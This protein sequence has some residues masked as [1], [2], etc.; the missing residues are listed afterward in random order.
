[1]NPLEIKDIINSIF[2]YLAN[3]EI[4]KVMPVSKFCYFSAAMYDG[5]KHHIRP[6]ICNLYQEY[7]KT[8]MYKYH[9]YYSCPVNAVC[10]CSASYHIYILFQRMRNRNNDV[11]PMSLVCSNIDDFGVYLDLYE[12]LACHSIAY[13]YSKFIDHIS[14]IKEISYH[15][16][17]DILLEHMYVDLASKNNMYIMDKCRLSFPAK[18]Y[19]RSESLGYHI[20]Y[21]LKKNKYCIRKLTGSKHGIKCLY[22][23]MIAEI[24]KTYNICEVTVST[25]IFTVIIKL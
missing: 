13:K 22:E 24:A 12:K 11:W 20:V 25:A 10:K 1:M 15:K 8:Q 5:W 3:D 4:A 17:F 14:D 23:T 21:D 16:N 19:A 6:D 18:R 7:K 9:S 2:K